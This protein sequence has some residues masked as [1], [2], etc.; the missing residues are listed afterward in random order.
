V[1]TA[2][3]TVVGTAKIV[4]HGSAA[5]RFNLVLLS[6]GY[7]QAELGQFAADAQQFVN[8]LFSTAPFDG[9]QCGINV[10]RIDVSST[11]S[12]AD[13]PT[14]CGGTGAAPATY[15]DASFCNAGIQRLLLVNTTTVVN[16]LNAQVPQWHQALV[17]VNSPI[18]GGAGGTIGTTSKATG[19]EGIAIHEMG[20]SA[21]GLADEYEY[22]AGCGIDTTQNTYTGPEPAQPNITADS[23]RATIKWADLVAATTPMPTTSNPDCTQCDTQPSP[24]PAGTVGAFEGAGYF[25]CGLFR[26]EFDCMMRNLTGFCAVCRRRITQRLTPFLP[27]CTAPVFAGSSPIL[28]LIRTIVLFVVIALLGLLALLLRVFCLLGSETA[29]RQAESLGCQIAQLRFR[30]RHCRSGN[31]DPCLPL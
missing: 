30:I 5:S 9:L 26:P 22:W 18:W 6:D 10:Y 15:F 4:D 12:G 28:C 13:D 17:I 21:F 23:N 29:C 16:V 20:H 2:D 31:S 8:S 27:R 1:S 7:R 24:V 25:H 11:D 19:W 14:A 3:G